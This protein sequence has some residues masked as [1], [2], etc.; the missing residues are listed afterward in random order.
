MALVYNTRRM[1]AD[2]DAVFEPKQAVYAAARRVAE[3]HPDIPTDWLNDGVKAFLPGPD[4][5]ALTAMDAPGL[6]VSV[7]SP[8]YLLALKVQASRIDRD[9]D[10]I[11]LLASLCVPPAHS[12]EE[13]LAIAERVIGPDRLP[14]K[15]HY[16]VQSMFPT[17]TKRNQ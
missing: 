7:A 3:R 10:D 15:A 12:A 4:P 2:V 5:N 8:E 14:A 16:L 17:E 9:E 11:R 6:V 1:T 13:V